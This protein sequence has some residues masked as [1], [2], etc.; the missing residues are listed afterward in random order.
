VGTTPLRGLGVTP[1]K[2][3][4]RW[5]ASSGVFS[6][7]QGEVSASHIHSIKLIIIIKHPDIAVGKHPFLFYRIAIGTHV[8]DHLCGPTYIATR[9]SVLQ[10]GSC[11]GIFFSPNAT[12]TLVARPK[13]LALSRRET[14]RPE[15]DL[16]VLLFGYF[17]P[18]CKRQDCYERENEPQSAQKSLISW[19]GRS[20]RD[21][22]S[23]RPSKYARTRYPSLLTRRPHGTKS[24]F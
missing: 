18:D 14:I 23:N 9:I 10:T 24:V 17:F 21:K 22:A 1:K 20:H 2:P 6:R 7:C 12:L 19:L 4:T 8:V 16:F 5:K 11:S 13:V 15:I 3:L